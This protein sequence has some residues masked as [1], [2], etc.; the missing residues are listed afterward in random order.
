[1]SQKTIVNKA[2]AKGASTAKVN[3]TNNDVKF[4]DA[5]ST[6]LSITKT[7]SATVVYPG[8]ILTYTVVVTN[9]GTGTAASVAFEDNLPNSSHIVY[10]SYSVSG[11]TGTVTLTYDSTKNI[12]SGSLNDIA[13]SGVVTVTI[14]SN[15]VA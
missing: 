12:L 13:S 1:M 15:V 8:D 7:P 4:D 10:S 14:V 9:T 6:T 3:I 11:A 2:S 5:P